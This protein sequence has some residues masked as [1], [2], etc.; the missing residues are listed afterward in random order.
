MVGVRHLDAGRDEERGKQGEDAERDQRL[1]S[2]QAPADP[3]H[4]CTASRADAVERAVA[5]LGS[6]GRRARSLRGRPRAAPSSCRTGARWRARAASSAAR[7]GFRGSRRGRAQRSRRRCAGRSAI[8]GWRRSPRS[9][10][11]SCVVPVGERDQVIADALELG[12]DVGG[13]NDGDPFSTTA[14]ITAF[15]NSRRASGSSEATGSSSSNSRGRLASA[16]VSATCACWPPESW[17][18]FCFAERPRRSTRRGSQPLVPARVELA[19]VPERLG[20][21][22]VPVQWMVLRD[23]A[24]PRQHLLRIATG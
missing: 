7:Y 22:Q 2:L 21:R 17:P 20:D 9:I 6:R 15:R 18:I 16:S 12:D 24:N 4:D 8:D 3:G 14:S 5:G 23:E 1:G 13:E 10:R 11:S 19:A